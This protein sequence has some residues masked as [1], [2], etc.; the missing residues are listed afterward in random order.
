MSRKVRSQQGMKAAQRR[1]VVDPVI[2][3]ARSNGAKL[4]RGEFEVVP[5]PNPHGEVLKDGAP[6]RHYSIKR[7]PQFELLRSRRVITDKQAEI[8]AWYADRRAL[9]ESGM[10]RNPLGSTGGGGAGVG[11]PITEARMGAVHDIEWARAAVFGNGGQLGTALLEAFDAVMIDE[12]SF[13]EAVRRRRAK[14]YVL[15]LS[16]RKRQDKMRDLFVQAVE[17]IHEA[18]AERW[19]QGPGRIVVQSY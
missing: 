10:I 16:L 2:E 19:P 6:V 3:Q 14:R 13:V 5:V 7:K 12:I 9:A 8:L 1:A 18:Y 4:E 15:G 17:C 11:L